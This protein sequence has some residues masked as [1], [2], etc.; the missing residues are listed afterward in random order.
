MPNEY[1]LPIEPGHHSEIVGKTRLDYLIFDNG[2]IELQNVETMSDHRRKGSA[3]A[4]LQ[5][6]I[7]KATEHQM[8]IELFARPTISGAVSKKSL[9]A[10]YTRLGFV[11]KPN[12]GRLVLSA[13]IEMLQNP[14]QISQFDRIFDDAFDGL[15]EFHA[16]LTDE[17][18]PSMKSAVEHRYADTGNA[19]ADYQRLRDAIEGEVARNVQDSLLMEIERIESQDDR[20][21]RP[22]P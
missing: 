5:A 16:C 12:S 10:F 17:V 19:Q 20:P 9:H 8:S 2:T 1:D 6:L 4:A 22:R 7:V 15:R 21:R 13:R 3:K 14:C 11:E 18:K